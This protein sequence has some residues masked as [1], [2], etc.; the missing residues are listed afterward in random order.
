MHI[1]SGH[2]NDKEVQHEHC[3]DCPKVVRNKAEFNMH[4]ESVHSND[5]EVQH[6]K[7]NDGSKVFRNKAKLKMHIEIVHNEKCELCSKVFRNQLELK[8]HVDNVHSFE[9]DKSSLEDLGIVQKPE[10]MKMIKQNIKLADLEYD[11]DEDEYFTY[12]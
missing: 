2:S 7:C 10:T 11:L 4:I 12:I 9:G 1:E 5:K 8:K 3:N 6:E